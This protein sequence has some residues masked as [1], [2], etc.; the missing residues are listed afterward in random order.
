MDE[1][2]YLIIILIKITRRWYRSMGSS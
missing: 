1:D 2:M